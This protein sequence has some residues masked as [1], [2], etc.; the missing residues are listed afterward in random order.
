MW[1]WLKKLLTGTPTTSFRRV[2]WL[3][4]EHQWR[5]IEALA[6]SR[7]QANVKQA[8]IQAD[9]LVDSIFKQAGVA[10]TT[11]GERL[12]GLKTRTNP[13]VYRKLWQAHLKRNELVHEAGSFVADWERNQ[14]LKSFQEAVSFYRGMK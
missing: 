10:G 8:L 1:V 2:D 9:T 4:V 7:E 5:T 11:F 3:G 6:T 12:K 13:Q 14:H